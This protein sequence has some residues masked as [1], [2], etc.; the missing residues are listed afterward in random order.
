MAPV[1]YKFNNEA[2]LI[3][4]LHKAQKKADELYFDTRSTDEIISQNIAGNT[5]RAFRISKNGK[6]PSVIFKNWCYKFLIRSKGK[7]KGI[8]SQKEYDRFV[9]NATNALVRHWRKEIGYEVGWGRAAKLLNLVF[10][11]FPCWDEL[12]SGS[13]KRIIKYLHIPL[14]SY[15]ILG[16]KNIVDFHIPSNASMG[17]IKDKKMYESFQSEIRVFTKRAKVNAINYDILAWDVAHQPN[18]QVYGKL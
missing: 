12:N 1:A 16:L 11:L 9:L 6:R 14:D 3:R 18:K 10:K 5:F 2:E 17:W 15:S 13:R 7:I 8:S 4:G